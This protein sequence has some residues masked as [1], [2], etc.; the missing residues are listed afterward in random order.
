MKKKFGAFLLTLVLVLGLGTAAYAGG[1]GAGPEPRPPFRPMSI[2][3]PQEEL[4]PT[5][6]P[7]NQD[8]CNGDEQ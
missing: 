3:L 5:R 7:R 4:P 8:Y 6:P 1:G 2:E